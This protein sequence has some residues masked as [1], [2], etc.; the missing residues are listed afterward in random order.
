LAASD[1]GSLSLYRA[2][3]SIDTPDARNVGHYLVIDG[4]TPCR[5]R[6][7]RRVSMDIDP[8]S[9]FDERVE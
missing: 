7:G 8:L 1:P 4:S 3:A 5:A 9:S 6:V 2:L